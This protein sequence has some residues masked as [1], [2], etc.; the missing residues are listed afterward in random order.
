MRRILHIIALS[1]TC[2]AAMAETPYMEK[3]DEADKAC[4]EGKWKEAE[5]ALLEALRAE[6]AN[7]SNILLISN[8]GM[9]RFNMGEDSLALATLDDA[10]AMAPASVTILSN[11]ARVLTAI[12]D[13]AGAYEDYTR[14]LELDSMVMTARFHHGLLALKNRKFPTAKADFD[15]MV[16]KF[17]DAEETQIGMATFLSSIGEYAE[18]LPYYNKILLTQK[19]P[20]YYGARAYCYLMTNHLQEASDD[21]G[22]AM[23]LAP[24]D[25]ELYLYR[26]ALNKMRFRPDDANADAKRAIELGVDPNRALPLMT[27]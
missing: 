13:E 6:P 1:L 18:A 20:E 15:F 2:A 14:I 25:G 9:V 8:L 10:H 11:R 23:E 3:V 27:K 4:A 26:A 5:T 22:V 17:P 24:D 7:P 21:I 16:D 19:E 12:G